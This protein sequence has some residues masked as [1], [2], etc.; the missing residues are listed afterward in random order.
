MFWHTGERW[1]VAAAGVALALAVASLYEAVPFGAAVFVAMAAGIL[2]SVEARPSAPL[3][4]ARAI[5]GLGML[6]LVPSIFVG[7]LW[8]GAN[9]V[10]MG[11]PLF[12]I[13]GAYGYSSYQGD[14]FTSDSTTG[15]GDPAAVVALLAPRVWP[16]LVPLAFVLAGPSGRRPPVAGRERDADR[17]RAEHHGRADRADGLP[18][19]AHGLPALRD[20]PALRGGGLGAVRDRQEPAAPAGDRDRAGGVGAGHPRL[21]CS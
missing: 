8:I 14:A 4:R 16:F 2:W 15:E 1:W 17:G 11:D 21:R 9:A 5:E 12:F 19:I 20:L 18:R 7:L 3:G 6:L 13:N 10:I